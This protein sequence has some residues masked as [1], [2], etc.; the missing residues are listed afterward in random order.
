M[1]GREV[2]KVNLY[3][4]YVYGI[5]NWLAFKI[6]ESQKDFVVCDEQGKVVEISLETAWNYF[7][8]FPISL[9]CSIRLFNQIIR[10]EK[11]DLR[12]AKL[13]PK[14]EIQYAG[15]MTKEEVLKTLRRYISSAFKLRDESIKELDEVREV[16]R[17]Q[18]IEVENFL[19]VKPE[20]KLDMVWRKRLKAGWV[21][22]P[23][24]DGALKW[25][26]L[27]PIKYKLVLF[28]KEI[29]SG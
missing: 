18:L 28:D 10:N 29:V 26:W 19:K 17:K 7:L 2:V 3:E 16:A 27:R 23:K 1:Q 21:L 11:E 20:S 6:I 15:Y 9:P 24:K 14:P 22:I 4:G 8:G 25:V 13:N 12:K 5:P